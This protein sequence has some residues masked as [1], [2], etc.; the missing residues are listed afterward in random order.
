MKEMLANRRNKKL[1]KIIPVDSGKKPSH[2]SDLDF[3]ERISDRMKKQDNSFNKTMK[4]L[5]QNV[6]VFINT[7]SSAFQMMP[8]NVYI[9]RSS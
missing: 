8:H 6:P 1:T 9:V 5:Q 2:E 4:G 7:I 3:R